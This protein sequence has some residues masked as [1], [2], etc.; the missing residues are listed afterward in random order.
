MFSV[1]AELIQFL[2]RNFIIFAPPSN[3]QQVRNLNILI[4]VIVLTILIDLILRILA[5]WQELQDFWL[6]GNEN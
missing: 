1:K 6:P 4:Y 2:L 5:R 3:R